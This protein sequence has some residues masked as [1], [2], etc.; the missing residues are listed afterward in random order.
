MLMTPWW[1]WSVIHFNISTAF[2]WDSL[3]EFL[4]NIT[5]TVIMIMIKVGQ[6]LCVYFQ[7]FHSICMLNN[8]DSHY[9]SS[10][11]SM[12]TANIYHDGY[13]FHT[14]KTA[15]QNYECYLKHQKWYILSFRQDIVPWECFQWHILQSLY[16]HLLERYS[17][18][19]FSMF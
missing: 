7:E 2:L 6:T 8:C 9:V 12:I 17:D 5:S 14:S 10:K 11:F 13:I 18:N 1:L 3:D 16:E 15:S 19:F 4:D